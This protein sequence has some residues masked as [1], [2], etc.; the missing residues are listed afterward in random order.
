MADEKL[1]DTIKNIKTKSVLRAVSFIWRLIVSCLLLVIL[2]ALFFNVF[3]NGV[4]GVEEVL[5][6]IFWLGIAITC[7]FEL[8][9][10]IISR[11]V[12]KLLKQ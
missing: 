5:I 12:V 2:L 11:P 4:D 6:L 10:K 3:N 7:A 1:F 9:S 8:K